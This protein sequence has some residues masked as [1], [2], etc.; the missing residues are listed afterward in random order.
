MGKLAKLLSFVRTVRR[1]ANVSDS[2]VDPGGG[3][4][5]TSEHFAPVGDDSHPLPGDYVVAVDVQ[6]TGVTAAVGYLDPANA[7]KTQPGGK[8]IYSRDADGNQVAEVWLKNDG[9]IIADNGGCTLTLNPDG[10]ATAN[11]DI[12]LTVNVP[13]TIFNSNVRING[14]LSW[15]GIGSGVGG[16]AIMN[17]GITNTGGNIVS[18]GVGLE[19]HTHE[20]GVDSDGDSEVTTDPPNAV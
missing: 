18:D 8:R 10:T 5:I 2:K 20:Q 17:G 4:N 16:P 14:N 19:T 9:T 1:G 15:S 6:R 7:Q 12:L 3:E 11:F 13:D